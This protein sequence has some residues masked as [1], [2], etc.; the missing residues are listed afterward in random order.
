MSRVWKC[1]LVDDK[2][3][4]KLRIEKCKLQIAL[5][6]VRHKFAIVNLQFSI[7]QFFV[8]ELKP[9]ALGSH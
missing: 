7:F 5:L 6:Q 1:S 3:E 4:L 8:V 2:G 9:F